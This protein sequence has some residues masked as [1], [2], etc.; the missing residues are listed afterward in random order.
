MELQLPKAP[1]YRMLKKSGANRISEDAVEELAKV[2]ETYA[3]NV[4]RTAM[5]TVKKEKRKTVLLRDITAVIG[6][7]KKAK[8]AKKPTKKAKPKK[9]TKKPAKKAKPKKTKK[10]KK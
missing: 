3:R 10:K 2:V 6:V 4:V 7:P 1:F 8:P 9:T 5:K